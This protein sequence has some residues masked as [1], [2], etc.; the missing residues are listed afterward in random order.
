[1]IGTLEIAAP[2][3]HVGN[4]LVERFSCLLGGVVRTFERDIEYSCKVVEAD[5]VEDHRLDCVQ[6]NDN[7]NDNDTQRSPSNNR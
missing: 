2:S 5:G 6:T 7:D 4:G 3:D 1:M